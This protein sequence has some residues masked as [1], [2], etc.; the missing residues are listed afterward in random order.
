MCQK[1]N[2]FKE[3]IVKFDHIKIRTYVYQKPVVSFVFKT[4]QKNPVKKFL[5][6]IIWKQLRY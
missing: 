4:I 5:E 1:Q 2:P 6:Y 3:Y